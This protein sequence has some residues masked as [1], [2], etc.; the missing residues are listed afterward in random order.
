MLLRYAKWR[1]CYANW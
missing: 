1:Q